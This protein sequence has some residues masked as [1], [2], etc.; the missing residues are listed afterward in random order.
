MTKIKLLFLLSVLGF[1]N[2]CGSEQAK[3]PTFEDKASQSIAEFL[4][5][6]SVSNF[7]ILDTVYKIGLDSAKAQYSRAQAL[8]DSQLVRLP[9]LVENTKDRL[10]TA[11]NNLEAANDAVFVTGYQDII[12]GEKRNLASFNET[13]NKAQ[14]LKEKNVEWQKFLDSAYQALDGDTAYF[15]IEVKNGENTP[16]LAVTTSCQVL[17]DFNKE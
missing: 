15:L 16:K 4:S 17:I 5:V 8:I 12:A 13:L 6:D 14:N 11:Q 9:K 3:E 2:S 1:L 10:E 7:V